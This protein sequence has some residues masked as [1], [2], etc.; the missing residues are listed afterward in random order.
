MVPAVSEEPRASAQEVPEVTSTVEVEICVAPG[1]GT[2]APAATSIQVLPTWL[3]VAD[4][5]QEPPRQ[6]VV[7][8]YTRIVGAFVQLIEL[9]N[10]WHG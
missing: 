1:D 2:S 5:I 6:E 10:P 9:R 4:P 8:N 7:A 3:L